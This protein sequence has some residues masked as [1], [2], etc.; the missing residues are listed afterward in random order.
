MVTEA[1]VEG[2]G[3]TAVDVQQGSHVAQRLGC[4]YAACGAVLERTSEPIG[5]A[6]IAAGIQLSLAGPTAVGSA[7]PMARALMRNHMHGCSS[8][9]WNPI[10]GLF[11]MLCSNAGSLSYTTCRVAVD[12]AVLPG[13]KCECA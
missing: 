10:H 1:R 5:G 12:M 13:W 7:F 11:M 4:C 6:G 8:M 2:R 3:L 9:G